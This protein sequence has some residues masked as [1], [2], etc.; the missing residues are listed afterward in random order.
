MTDQQPTI[1]TSDEPP[2]IPPK[3]RTFHD[4]PLWQKALI[5]VLVLWGGSAIYSA[6]T[7]SGPAGPSTSAPNPPARQATPVPVEPKPPAA[8]TIGDGTHRVGQDIQPGTYRLREPASGCYWARLSGFG[9]TLDE[10]Y[11]NE[12]VNGYGVVTIASS[13]AGFETTGCGGW[14]RDLSTVTSGG[15]VPEGTLIVGTDLRPGTYRSTGGDG[16]YWARLG[17]FSGEL[18]DI[19]ANENA[20]GAAVV[21]IA[22][23]DEGFTSQRCGTWSQ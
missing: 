21:T 14:S 3:K 4:R 5:V 13:D 10:I 17:G 16:C 8:A 2:P 7:R 15:E 1:V 12:N 9:G 18:D 11:A 23:G 22:T 20:S 19:I 6:V